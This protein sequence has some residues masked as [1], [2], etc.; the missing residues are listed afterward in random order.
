MVPQVVVLT[1]TQGSQEKDVWKVDMYEQYKIGR[2]IIIVIYWHVAS[3]WTRT[4][5]LRHKLEQTLEFY[6]QYN[7]KTTQVFDNV[8]QRVV[9]YGILN[10]FAE[11]V[12]NSILDNELANIIK[13]EC[14]FCFI[15]LFREVF[16]NFDPFLQ[17]I[18]QFFAK[19]MKNPNYRS[20]NYKSF[21]KFTKMRLCT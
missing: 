17:E 14:C 2:W 19:M 10:E 11:R 18:Q 15:T 21:R 9:E 5:K 12:Q 4:D 8:G 7:T 6:S 13:H 20:K 16:V 1:R 3:R